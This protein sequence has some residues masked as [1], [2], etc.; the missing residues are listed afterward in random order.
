[1]EYKNEKMSRL[2]MIIA[3]RKNQGSDLKEIVAKITEWISHEIVDTG[4]IFKLDLY[5]LTENGLFNFID[6]GVLESHLVSLLALNTRLVFKKDSAYVYSFECKK[7]VVKLMNLSKLQK[8]IYD[9]YDSNRPLAL[10]ALNK[11]S[12]ND[13]Q[14]METILT[15]ER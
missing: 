12:N 7:K 1:M 9:L 15:F 10:T 5:E 11:M 2:E 14:E 6:M 3:E 8:L 4:K 13:R